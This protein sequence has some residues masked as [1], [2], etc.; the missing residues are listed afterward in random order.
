MSPNKDNFGGKGEKKSSW[1]LISMSHAINDWISFNVLLP[2][3]A[4]E[5]TSGKQWTD[6]K[7][8]VWNPDSQF[9]WVNSKYQENVS[10][11]ESITSLLHPTCYLK[12]NQGVIALSE[13]GIKGHIFQSCLEML[14]LTQF[15]TLL[16]F[17]FI[18]KTAFQEEIIKITT[19]SFPRTSLINF[20]KCFPQ[21]NHIYL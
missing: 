15:W 14:S 20:K 11:L 3:E 5:R 1:C 17:F 2:R 16:I 21:W 9:L 7:T 18:Q 13:I 10:C 19:S 8:R 4:N 6:E 12:V